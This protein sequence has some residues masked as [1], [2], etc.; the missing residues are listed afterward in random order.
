MHCEAHALHTEATKRLC[1]AC[2][3]VF[4][5]AAVVSGSTRQMKSTARTPVQRLGSF[6]TGEETHKQMRPKVLQC[7]WVI[8]VKQPY[9]HLAHTRLTSEA[10][11]NQRI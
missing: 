6:L 7:Y 8:V 10:E 2:Y 9:I 11:N 1:P 3:L 4:L 5:V